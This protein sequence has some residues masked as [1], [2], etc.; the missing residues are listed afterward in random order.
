M[1]SVLRT[2]AAFTAHQKPTVGDSKISF[3]SIDHLGWLRCDGRRLPI[4]GDYGLLY[5]VIGTTFGGDATGFNLPDASGVVPGISSPAYPTGTL[6]GEYFH[7]LTIAEMPSHNH[8]TDASDNIVG[9]NQTGNAGAH[10]HPI[11]D[12]EHNHSYTT[13]ANANRG[14]VAATD[15]DNVLGGTQT[16]NTSLQATGITIN[17]A[18]D[19]YH[20]I[21]TQGS[22][23]PHNNMQPTLFIGNLFIYCGDPTAGSWPY[24][25][26]T[27]IY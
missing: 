22:N 17:S 12:P 4:E 27:N 9:N 2:N 7:T 16:L 15:N 11:T 14:Y 1:T 23:Q 19:H 25:Q 3:V 5:K 13:Y 6:V 10:T 24:F 8:G 20:S 21:A 18:G 26:G